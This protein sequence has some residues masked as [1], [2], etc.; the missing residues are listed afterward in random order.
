MN[1]TAVFSPETK[2]LPFQSYSEYTDY[3]FSCV[4]LQLSG[5]I[6]GLMRHIAQE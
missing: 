4:D 5:Y 2:E 3:L 1:L 6:R